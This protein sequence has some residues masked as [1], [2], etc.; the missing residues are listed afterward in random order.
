MRFLFCPLKF[1]T[2]LVVN[3]P[4]RLPQVFYAVVRL[5]PVL[6]VCLWLRKFFVD[7][8]PCKAV[9]KV[10][11]PIKLNPDVAV[12]VFCLGWRSGFY[13]TSAYL[14][15]EG[16]SFGVVVQSGK[17]ALVSKLHVCSSIQKSCGVVGKRGIRPPFGDQPSQQFAFYGNKSTIGLQDR[18]KHIEHALAVLSGQG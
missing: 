9:G 18:I 14:P 8:K 6:V 12:P 10:A 7:V 15:S 16:P 17:Q 1:M 2:V 4:V 3:T 5:D 13:A 11:H